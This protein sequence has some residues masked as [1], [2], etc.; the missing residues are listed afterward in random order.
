MFVLSV[1]AGSNWANGSTRFTGPG[2]KFSD[3]NAGRSGAGRLRLGWAQRAG[4]RHL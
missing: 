3:L 1:I 2:A 4:T